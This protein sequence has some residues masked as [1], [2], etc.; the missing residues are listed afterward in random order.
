[1]IN[2]L[3]KYKPKKISEIVGNKGE[4]KHFKQFIEQ[5]LNNPSP[6]KI[7]SPNLL[8][9]GS[10]GIGKTLITDLILQEYNIDKI[11][12]NFTNISAG[13]KKKT[14]LLHEQKN[15]KDDLDISFNKKKK[16]DIV[17]KVGVK[18][19]INTYYMIVGNKKNIY[20][21]KEHLSALVFDNVSGITNAKEKNIIKILLKLNNKCKVFP[22]II[23]A[24]NKHNKMVNEIR[25][26][27]EYETNK[28]RVKNQKINKF[29]NE[30]ILGMPSYNDMKSYIMN[31]CSNEKLKLSK[32]IKYDDIYEELIYY[33]QNDF[34]RLLIILEELKLMYDDEIITMKIFEKYQ[35]TSKKKNIDPGIFENTKFLLNNYTSISDALT[36]Y[37]TDRATIPLIVHEN[38]THNIKTQYPKMCIGDQIN[39]ISKISKSISE[40][41]KI[42]G[43]I[44][45][46]QL[47]SLQPVHGFYSCVLPSYFINEQPNKLHNYELYKYTQDY[48]KT[49]TKKINN[50]V[51]YKAQNHNQLKKL[52]SYDL[53]YMASILKILLERKDFD[54]VTSLIKT[55]NLTVKDIVS[56]IKID[57]INDKR[58]T[59]TGKQCS[60]LKKKL[61][62]IE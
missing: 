44:Y 21:N 36:F 49:S 2:W 59:L 4:I 23:I 50:M 38:Y 11:V 55:Y 12:G 27:L 45:S 25:K 19:S 9:S 54:T 10:N 43:L 58:L 35:E 8:I 51:I 42:D 17:E 28:T 6:D 7:I 33:S 52:S 37:S 14:N 48:N 46:N 34:R 22:I 20:G 62:S 30:I 1:M 39:L 5:F 24:N 16:D 41:D 60:I 29:I 3:D 18:R 32:N 53:L 61:E 31:I 56:I 57:K 26:M 40:S 13:K 15:S 47:W